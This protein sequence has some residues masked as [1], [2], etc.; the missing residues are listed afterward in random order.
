VS[1]SEP[2]VEVYR[3]SGEGVAHEIYTEGQVLLPCVDAPLDLY[4][5]YE[6]VELER[7]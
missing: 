1:A 6:D 5:L 3:K 7:A 2:R 4:A